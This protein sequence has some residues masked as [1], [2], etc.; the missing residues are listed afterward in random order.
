MIINLL[1]RPIREHDRD[2][3]LVAA[4]VEWV[5]KRMWLFRLSLPVMIPAFF[6]WV[7]GTIKTLGSNPTDASA[8]AAVLGGVVYFGGMFFLI[9]RVPCKR[10][11]IFRADGSIDAPEGLPTISQLVLKHTGFIGH[12]QIGSIEVGEDPEHGIDV[13]IYSTEGDKIVVG[14]HFFEPDFAHKIAV[15]LQK[16]LHE[17]RRGYSD[18][19]QADLEQQMAEM[20]RRFRQATAHA[21]PGDTVNITID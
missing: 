20:D 17:I 2:G 4:G 19:R 6:I 3:N 21:R 12:A 14:R 7:G 15:L 16:A 18:E 13:R 1:I 8:A 5:E 10:S 11:L 9:R